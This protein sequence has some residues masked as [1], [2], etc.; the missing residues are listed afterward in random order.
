MIS[1][2]S[3]LDRFRRKWSEKLSINF[4]AS[5]LLSAFALVVVIIAVAIP[6]TLGTDHKVY[7]IGVVAA[8]LLSIVL[9]LIK[10]RSDSSS[11]LV[12][13]KGKPPKV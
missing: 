9:L 1:D 10:A 7:I 3:E 13:T 6:N 4:W 11:L 12:W 5:V 8:G 2:E